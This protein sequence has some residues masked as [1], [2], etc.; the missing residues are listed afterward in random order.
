MTEMCVVCKKGFRDKRALLKHCYDH[1]K[2]SEAVLNVSEQEVEVYL[3]RIEDYVQK[4]SDAPA[5]YTPRTYLRN[6]L[7]DEGKWRK[8]CIFRIGGTVA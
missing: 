1:L 7:C 5:P 8:I 2:S 6:L 3:A 4:Y